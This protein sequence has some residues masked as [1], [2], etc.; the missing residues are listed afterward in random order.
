MFNSQEN[1]MFNFDLDQ[2]EE[3]SSVVPA[4]KY[5][6]QV[7]KVEFVDTKTG[8]KMLKVMFNIID[9]NQN[10]R[11]LFETFNLVHSNDKV[12]QISLGQIKSIVLSSGASLQKFTSPEQLLGLECLA[13]VK[14]KTSDEY[15]DQNKI[16][17][18][19]K[20]NM[21]QAKNMAPPIPQGADGKPVF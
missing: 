11:K 15:G 1:S 2:V 6:V 17:N 14:V 5:L 19:S 16:T 4:G 18:Y 3:S 12:V 9:D 20:P 7:E 21:E 8:G 10:G 13:T